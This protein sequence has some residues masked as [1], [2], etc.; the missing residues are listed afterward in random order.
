MNID[1]IIAELTKKHYK[2]SIVFHICDENHR[3]TETVVEK[4]I[5]DFFDEQQWQ[6]GIKMLER[7]QVFGGQK[8]EKCFDDFWASFLV[9]VNGDLKSSKAL[10]RGNVLNFES[11][12]RFLLVRLGFAED[13]RKIQ[14]D[15]KGL[16][17]V[18]DL[19]T[20]KG[21]MFKAP[22]ESSHIME[23]IACYRNWWGHF[24][25]NTSE[26]GT[27]ELRYNLLDIP[28]EDDPVE[29]FP[30]L[31]GIVR[32][33]LVEL[34]LVVLDKYQDISQSI[35]Q[36]S[37][38]PSSELQFEESSFLD[39]YFR[40][41]QDRLERKLQTEAIKELK[42][43]NEVGYFEHTFRFSHSNKSYDDA[44]VDTDN[45]TEQIIKLSQF[46]KGSKYKTNVIL[47]MPGAGKT[48]ALYLLVNECIHQFNTLED[49]EKDKAPIPIFI[50]LKSISL[51]KDSDAIRSAI[52][53]QVGY[54]INEK[55]NKYREDAFRFIY[56]LID[57]GRVI[58]FFDGL[59]E[60]SPDYRNAV[61]SS[62]KN[63]IRLM[64]DDSRIFITGR[65]YEYEGSS[66]AKELVELDNFAIWHL[67]E[68][69]F[70]QIESF[71]SP[72][73]CSQIIKGQIVELFS[74]P[75]NLRLF[76]QFLKKH[77]ADEDNTALEVPLNR[78][79]ILDAFLADTYRDNGINPYFAN[80]LL[81]A[82]AVESRGGQCNK[83]SFK[84]RFEHMPVDIIDRLAA[85]NVLSLS[86]ASENA[87]EKVSFSIDTFQEFYRAKYVIDSLCDNKTLSLYS[88]SEDKCILNPRSTDDFETLKL[89]FEIGSSPLC[90]QKRTSQSYQVARKSAIEFSFRLAKDFLNPQDEIIKNEC[91][92]SFDPDIEFKASINDKLLTLCELVR[93]VPFSRDINAGEKNSGE[94]SRK[95]E[96]NAKDVA[97]LLVLNN[98]KWFRVKH[99]ETVRIIRQTQEYSYLDSLITA[100]SIIGGK[101]IWDELISSY[102][103][104]TFGIISFYDFPIEDSLDYKEEIEKRN[105]RMIS[106]YTILFHLV[107][108]CRD[109]IYLY[110]EIHRLHVYY[111]KRKKNLSAFGIG[112]F[113]YQY[114]LCLIPSYAKRHLYNHINEAYRKNK[115]DIQLAADINTLLCYMG[116]S[117]LLL[118]N[119]KYES[120]CHIRIKELRYILRNYADNATQRFVLSTAFF[121]HLQEQYKDENLKSLTIRYFLF[122]LG[123]TPI[124]KDFLFANNGIQKIPRNEVEAIMDLIPLQSIPKEYIEKHYDKD[125]C[126]LLIR[127]NGE[128]VTGTEIEYVYFGEKNGHTLISVIDVVDSFV[129]ETCFIG[130]QS[131]SI[132]NDSHIDAVRL[133]CRI[134][135]AN[136]KDRILP[137]K[138]I[139]VSNNDGLAIPYR[140]S[141]PNT[142]LNLYLYGEDAVG[143]FFLYNEGQCFYINGIECVIQFPEVD[144]NT[145]LSY[146]QF[147][148]LEL[149]TLSAE[150]EAIPYSGELNMTKAINKVLRPS[151]LFHV[152]ELFEPL[153]DNTNLK[154][155]DICY[156]VFG[157]NRTSL[158]VLTEKIVTSADSIVGGI[159]VENESNASYKVCAIKP[160]YSPYY[161]FWF[162][163]TQKF[164][165]PTYGTF[166][167]QDTDG[168]YISIPYCFCS[169]NE[170]GMSF[171]LR[172]L[173]EDIPN[174][175]IAKFYNGSYLLGNVQLQVVSVERINSNR[176]FSLWTLQKQG[177]VTC[178]LCGSF[179]VARR[180]QKAKKT[181][182]TFSGETRSTIQQLNCSLGYYDPHS[183]EMLFF[184]QKPDGTIG[185]GSGDYN[186][187]KG[188]YLNN[189]HISS[190]H[191]PI[192]K[193]SEFSPQEI[194]RL[195]MRF[196][197]RSEK[198]RGYFYLEGA[199]IN[200]VRQKDDNYW[201]WYPGGTTFSANYF[202]DTIKALGHLQLVF[203]DDTKEDFCVQ[204]IREERDIANF[205]MVIES[206][207]D[208]AL[209]DSVTNNLSGDK[210]GHCIPFN[211]LSQVPVNNSSSFPHSFRALY[212]RHV[213]NYTRDIKQRGSIIVP[214]PIALSGADALV[215]D[216][217]SKWIIQEITKLGKN[218]LRISLKDKDG[219]IPNIPPH[220]GL[221][222]FI[223]SGKP[224]TLWYNHLYELIDRI[225]PEKYHA[226]LCGNI[227][228]EILAGA[229]ELDST[230]IDFFIKKS[231][232]SDLVMNPELLKKI[233]SQ[234]P[235]HFVFNIC[236]VLNSHPLRGLEAYSAILGKTVLSSDTM[237]ESHDD[238]TFVW[239]DLVLMERNHSLTL[240]NNLPRYHCL[241]YKTGYV[242]SV[243]NARSDVRQY[244]NR[245]RVDIYCDEQ[246]KFYCFFYDARDSSI[247]FS[248]GDNVDFFATINYNDID[249]L[250]AENAKPLGGQQPIITATFIGKSIENE[251][252][253]FTFDNAGEKLEI[254]INGISNNKVEQ[255]NYLQVG[256][257][258][259]IIKGSRLFIVEK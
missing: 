245:K 234:S 69:S 14:Q 97:E 242:V 241:G 52:R 125:I 116:D 139:I 213:V 51:Q 21:K 247:S 250:A 37:N 28:F 257:S 132:V 181:P 148:V 231:H 126:E 205:S 77:Q 149:K 72:E 76:L 11:Y 10:V 238:R 45:D 73:I 258:Y 183:G 233:D 141:S 249:K 2:K 82:I 204:E 83:D 239:Q 182:I 96:N 143:L 168:V 74:S 85:V 86:P 159:V 53:E 218:L 32:L 211:I 200:F 17:L 65:E 43:D 136:E 228:E 185:A 210:E 49:E 87:P 165:I 198:C 24:P 156:R 58:L 154:N 8:G 144:R 57:E 153:I 31:G 201:I 145:Q 134:Q 163:I 92:C 46:R 56:K 39:V 256:Q 105:K 111:I 232:A 177:P 84:E 179:Y 16:R 138:G 161:E 119:F 104:L 244:E 99:P 26:D 61:I 120:K 173:N 254:K 22:T 150:S 127:E 4:R 130:N 18:I 59:N 146:R 215:L 224:I 158:W 255:Y 137:E 196:D 191:F 75:L 186:L 170:D 237:P 118:H 199:R 236:R 131:Y 178:P 220:G 20:K 207:C 36:F 117:Q 64:S 113:L 33:V 60:I 67:E 48:T 108:Y 100:S 193:D 160:H 214:K 103:L 155:D 13:V 133:Y 80:L 50:P 102:W 128:E 110:N 235:N 7:I 229:T 187:L 192:D 180:K 219:H 40:S 55:D 206:H 152:P 223:S 169:K 203:D 167:F 230:T 90:H 225:H 122:R 164:S 27:D 222:R 190:M 62:L 174:L 121:D 95:Q 107:T 140:A 42:T 91:P 70:E 25:T 142:E 184:A 202:E 9:G 98:L 101:L 89:L 5:S 194:R 129:G 68:L 34:L 243:T 252:V 176:R 30:L 112:A 253:L 44:S 251:Q 6:Q 135:A 162:K 12:L 226:D 227:L 79:E 114:F 23:T 1:N 71:L 66:Y 246:E 197:I 29:D 38:S 208:S 248:P 106:S 217:G 93:N 88:L 41:L 175:P 115:F 188:L 189:P 171:R 63:T 147:R 259:K 35:P 209:P 195:F 157:Q 109:Y 151:S 240:V 123:L 47:G 94:V 216:N 3:K 15:G 78:G 124:L 81:K 54:C 19:A 166:N 221:V 172:V 212:P